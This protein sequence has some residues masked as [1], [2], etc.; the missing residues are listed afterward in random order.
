MFYTTDNNSI[1]TFS[2]QAGVLG[3]MSTPKKFDS[4]QP[5][6]NLKTN[7]LEVTPYK[8]EDEFQSDFSKTLSIESIT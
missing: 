7:V 6:E 1:E 5:K 2:N 4:Q 8:A 3:Q